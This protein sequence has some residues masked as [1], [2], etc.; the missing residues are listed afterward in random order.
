MVWVRRSISAGLT[1]YVILLALGSL[2]W[3]MGRDQGI[4]A[5]A[6]DV[7]LDGGTPY[8]DAWEVK[9]PA[10]HYTF[11]LSRALFGSNSWGIR[12]LDLV[13][14][15][16][17]G[18]LLWRLV[19]RWADAFAAHVA[20]ILFVVLYFRAGYWGTA[21][22]DG[23]A[24]MFLLMALAMVLSDGRLSHVRRIAAGGLVGLAASYKL[25]FV[26][27]LAPLMLFDLFAHPASLRERLGRTATLLG[28]S[29]AVTCLFLLPLAIRGALG[30]F[31]DIQFNFNRVVHLN[32]RQ[33]PPAEHFAAIARFFARD[34]FLDSFVVFALGFGILCLGK[35]RRMLLT[36]LLVFLLLAVICT[37]G[38]AK[39]YG[40]HWR[41][42]Y[43]PI[44]IIAAIGVGYLRRIL[45]AAPS[46]DKAT[47]VLLEI[48]LLLTV[49]WL[50]WS[51]SPKPN[52][53]GWN[54]CVLGNMP[55]KDYYREFERPEAGA[56][57]LLALV[58][59]SKYLQQQTAEDDY[60]QVWGFKTLINT[61]CQ[62]RTPTRFGFNYPLIVAD[63]T[64]FQRRYRREFLAGLSSRRP[65]YIVIVDQ[66]TN[67][68]MPK[69]SRQYLDGFPAF[70]T[71]VQEK[72]FLDKT[73]GHCQLWRRKTR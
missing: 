13:L 21:Q 37:A 64:E 9:G 15:A 19:Q 33:R 51:I 68:L 43:G 70:A 57:P 55:R 72:Y 63:G 25:L 28:A 35:S 61:L 67:D 45:L 62:R 38:Q 65:A 36:T 49:G 27:F 71:Y 14:L 60:V 3:P 20:A 56:Y 41:P 52:W 23:W 59:V 53:S 7:I 24:S 1:A 48:G 31:C 22:P 46:L 2:W 6:G 5:W 12:L 50:V 4:F 54:A 58:Q 44:V 42:A 11:A 26:G 34:V 17:T 40:Y 29:V 66:D 10:T 39:Y 8:R 16:V 32:T 69:T 73:I 47:S 18:T 30:D